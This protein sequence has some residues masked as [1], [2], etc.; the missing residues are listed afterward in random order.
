MTPHEALTA[1][2]WGLDFDPP[3]AS[4]IAAA[5]IDALPPGWELVDEAYA[6][7]VMN[8]YDVDARRYHLDPVYH[9][10]VERIHRGPPQADAG[11]LLVSSL[12]AL[13]G[14][15]RR[16]PNAKARELNLLLLEKAK[17]WLR[18]NTD[19]LGTEPEAAPF[20]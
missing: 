5:A 7:L 3:D 12:A 17:A 13:E 11:L 15:V 16:S 9:G 10:I 6:R 18:A 4:R 1:A 2:L 19:Y 14:Q 8:G 20:A